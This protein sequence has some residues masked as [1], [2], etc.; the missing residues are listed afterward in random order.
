MSRRWLPLLILSVSSVPALAQDGVHPY[1]TDKFVIQAGAFFP[2]MNFEARVDGSIDI[3]L[4]PTPF[5]DFEQTFGHKQDD[6]I[7]AADLV[8]RFGK[9]WSFRGQYFEGGRLSS[10]TLQRDVEWGDALFSAGSNIEA[11]TGLEVFRLFFARDFSKSPQYEYGVGLGVHRLAV[12]AG[13]TGDFT[14]DGMPV[15]N[16]TRAVSETAPLPNIGGWWAWSPVEKWVLDARID[17]LDAT[18]QEYSGG[19]INAAIGVNYQLFPNVGVGLK[20]QRLR[21]QLDVDKPEWRGAVKLQYEGAY[22]YVS[23]NWG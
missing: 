3:T 2:K 13:L 7:F 17:W 21:L 23:A 18:I 5:Y 9:M 11:R 12:G 15:F 16:E 4:P 22:L 6:D 1:L 14:V 10:I 20:W 19:I 8:W